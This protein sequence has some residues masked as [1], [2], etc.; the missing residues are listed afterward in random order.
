MSLKN[1]TEKEREMMKNYVKS[2][3]ANSNRSWERGVKYAASQIPK[4]FKELGVGIKKE[5]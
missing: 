4:I 1:P 3:M 2:C 5:K